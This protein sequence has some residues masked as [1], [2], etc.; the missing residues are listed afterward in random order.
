MSTTETP[1]TPERAAPWTF[2]LAPTGKSN[3][4]LS[5]RVA[6]AIRHAESRGITVTSLR[7]DLDASDCHEGEAQR[8]RLWLKRC[9]RGHGLRASWP[10]S[11][12][13]GAE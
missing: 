10:A 5:E 4:P 13:G 1:T 3:D 8:V 11:S 2:I 7:I 12:D 6:A 9:L